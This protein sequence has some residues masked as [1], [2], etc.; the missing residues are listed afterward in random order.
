MGVNVLVCVHVDA[1]SI[2]GQHHYIIIDTPILSHTT[3][4]R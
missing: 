1:T 4:G 2:L 3:I